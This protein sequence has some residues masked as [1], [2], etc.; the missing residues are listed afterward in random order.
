MHKKK[1]HCEKR[2]GKGSFRKV[3]RKRRFGEGKWGKAVRRSRTGK[4]VLENGVLRNYTYDLRTTLAV[5]RAGGCLTTKNR[6]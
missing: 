4:G 2:V 5:R 3:Q 1:A 6:S